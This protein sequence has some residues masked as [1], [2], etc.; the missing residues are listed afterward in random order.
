[1]GGT[2]SWAA[3]CD[4]KVR[5]CHADLQCGPPRSCW[6]PGPMLHHPAAGA[7]R[8]RGAQPK[9]VEPR[10]CCE[11]V[12]RRRP[13]KGRCG[14]SIP[15]QRGGGLEAT[16]GP[17]SFKALNL[18]KQW[19]PWYVL[20]MQGR[21][22][23]ERFW[24]RVNKTEACWM[25]LGKPKPNGYGTI[26]AGPRGSKRWYAHRLSWAI[27]NGAIPDG[28]SVLHRCD[29][30]ACVN[31]GHLFLGTQA[32]NVAD[33]HAKGREARGDRHGL[34]LHPDRAV[35]GDAHWSKTP[36][37]RNRAMAS[38]SKANEKRPTGTRHGRSR[39]NA[40]GL[41]RLFAMRAAGESQAA[42]AKA[43][44]VTKQIV[45]RVERGKSYRSEGF[46]PVPRYR[47]R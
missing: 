5:F 8:G 25:W 44:G 16:P 4:F 36:E 28:L 17:S 34:R 20:V 45:S 24:S 11:P 43:L 37:G 18:D 15:R 9:R 22:L 27:H 33:M 13:Q 7:E 38:L 1:M 3:H 23:E 40:D 14:C 2:R 19:S 39:L 6:R 12:W 35:R 29:V 30:R 41:A 47:S 21:P 42:I 26:L 31:P 46:T 32:D 10:N